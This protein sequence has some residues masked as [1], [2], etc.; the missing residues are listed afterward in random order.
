MTPG[1]L[2]LTPDG[3]QRVTGSL[4]CQLETLARQLE[5]RLQGNHLFSNLLA[6]VFA[7]H[8]LDGPRSES[9]LRRGA[10]LGRELESQILSDGAHVERSPMYHALLLENLLDLIN[11]SRAAPQPEARQLLEAVEERAAAMLGALRVWTHPDGEIALFADSALGVA[12]VPQK[13]EDYAASLGVQPKAPSPS[14]VLNAAGY[15]RLERDPFTLI[16]SVAGPMPSYQPGHAHCDALAFELSVGRE[17][18]VTDS[19]VYEYLPGARR[20]ASRCTRA[21]ATAE[22]D[23]Q[24]QAEIWSAHRVG[25]RPRVA[26]ESV[27]PGRSA[28]ASCAGWATPDTIHRRVFRVDATGVEIHDRLEGRLRPLR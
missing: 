3:L 4:A 1:A 13:L 21:H 23:G 20:R 8:L 17:R 24:E 25:G 16:A 19:G 5:V 26:L 9:W 22:V 27:E 7:G 15:V 14:G 2:E 10:G 28:H 12:H 6:L 18:V 11:L